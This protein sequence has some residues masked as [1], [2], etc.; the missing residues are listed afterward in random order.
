M[1]AKIYFQVYASKNS[2]LLKV[3]KERTSLQAF[4]FKK[5]LKKERKQTWHWNPQWQHIN[6]DHSG[7]MFLGNSRIE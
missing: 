5:E 4:R 3:K 6:Q 1:L 7:T 2:G